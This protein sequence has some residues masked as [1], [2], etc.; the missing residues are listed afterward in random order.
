MYIYVYI[1]WYN[2]HY[3]LWVGILPM[4]ER[5]N[6][7]MLNVMKF[8]DLIINERNELIF[9]QYSPTIAKLFEHGTSTNHKNRE[10]DQNLF[11][12]S[13]IL[14]FGK[15]ENIFYTFNPKIVFISSRIFKFK[16]QKKYI[17][18]SGRAET[19]FF[20]SFSQTSFESLK[21]RIVIIY[22]YR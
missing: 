4:D 19:T 2:F 8:I 13:N 7:N 6:Y 10:F 11:L 22:V 21:R 20:I 14:L 12:S 18:C 1:V 3:G 16:T 17:F 15:K 5:V 9:Y